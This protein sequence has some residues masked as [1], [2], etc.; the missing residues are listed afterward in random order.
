[1]AGFLEQT[2]QNIRR[3]GTLTY[4]SASPA[5][6]PLPRVGYLSKLL[7]HV[8]GTMTVTPGTG[9]AALSEKGPFALLRRVR[10]QIGSGTELFNVSGFGTYLVNLFQKYQWEPD[11]GQIAD[12]TAATLLYRAGV[13]SGANLWDFFIEIPVVPNDRDLTGLILLQA[14]GTVTNLL[15]EWQVAGGATADFPVVLTGNATASFV[16]EARCYLETFTVPAET[17]SQAP[18]DQVHQIIERIDPITSTGEMAIRLLEENTYLRI[19]HSIEVNGA[20]S[21]VAVDSMKF[22]YNLTDVPYDVAQ[23]MKLYLQRR[24][25][26]KDFPK[27]TYFWDF[28][29]QGYPNYGGDRDLVMASGLAQLESMITIASGTVLG[30]NNNLVRTIT[31]QLIAVDVPVA[32]A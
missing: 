2:R 4:A 28:F 9:S 23:Q 1:M 13:A 5:Q 30:S 26:G 8:T 15:L 19:I 6:L 25:Y 31:Q 11:D 3:I 21:T 14:E 7:I 32:S 10:Y 12:T 29:D 18:L 17:D 16:G 27:G 20:L 24:S 22:R